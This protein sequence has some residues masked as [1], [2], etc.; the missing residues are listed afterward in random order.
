MAPFDRSPDLLSARG[1]SEKALDIE[2]ESFKIIDEEIGVHTYNPTEWSIVRRVIHSTADF[3]FARAAKIVFQNEA[4]SSGFDAIRQRCT[5]VCDVDMVLSALNK[6]SLTRLGLDAV[7]HIS[8]ENLVE[9]SRTSNKTRSQLAMRISS[10]E[11]NGGIVLIG[12][13][14]TALFETI[15]MINEGTT[16]PALVVGVPV[17]F[18]SASESKHALSQTAIPSITNNGRKGGSPAASSIMNALMLLAQK[19]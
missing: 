17:G 19:F 12:N 6:K 7:C 18:V 10:N 1:M 15:K 9:M 3:D 4:L 5:I 16:K 11:M 2:N 8:D 14:P 13:A